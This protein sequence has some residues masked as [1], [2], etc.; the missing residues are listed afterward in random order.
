VLSGTYVRLPQSNF[1]SV[2]NMSFM[3]RITCFFA[4]V[5]CGSATSVSASTPVAGAAPL[6]LRIAVLSDGHST[7][8]IRLLEESL[9]LIHQ[10]YQIHYVKDIPARRMWWM[11]EK[12]EI[13]LIYGMQS[14]E[15]E[16]SK[17][18]ILVRNALTN[19]LIGQ[20]VLLIRPADTKVFA[21]VQSVDDLKRTK[22]TAGLGAGWG[23]VKVWNAAGLPI[24]EHVAPWR[25]IYAMVA[26]GNRRVDYLPRGVIEALGEARSHPELAVEQHL[27][28]EYRADFSFYLGASAASYRPIIERAL[29]EAEVTGLKARL[30]DQAFG[31]DITTLGLDRR[32][33][34]RLSANAD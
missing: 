29:R 2:A 30:L 25:T 33:R 4:C 13:N 22:L 14:K 19:G 17:Q 27:L 23:D 24:Y 3:L 6:R 15:K 5:L 11:L 8:F 28:L 16:S 31:H 21:Q 20:R 34:L 10:P 18:L 12:G 1:E 32:L 9:K 26:A 7:Y